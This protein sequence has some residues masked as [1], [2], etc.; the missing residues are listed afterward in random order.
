MVFLNDEKQSQTPTVGLRTIGHGGSYAF[1]IKANGVRGGA[2]VA[3][4][5]SRRRSSC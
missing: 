5:P 1:E 2:L 4:A 3:F